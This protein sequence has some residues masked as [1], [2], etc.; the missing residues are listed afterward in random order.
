MWLR[1]GSIRGIFLTNLAISW[2]AVRLS[3]SQ[4]GLFPWSQIVTVLI[5]CGILC[6]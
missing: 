6:L 4:E 3:A 5:Y 1:T 2:A